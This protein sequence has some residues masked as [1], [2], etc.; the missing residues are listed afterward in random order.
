MD[1]QALLSEASS[2]H[3]WII[4]LRRTIHRNPELM[5]EEVETSRLVQSTLGEL[6]IPFEAGIAET[7]V[8]ATLGNGAGPCVA[9]RADMDALPIQ[10]QADVDFRSEVAGKMHACGH[11]CHTAMLLG[12]AKLLK[13]HEDK[14]SG[15]VK[16]VFQPA[17]EGGAGGQRMREHGILKSPDVQRIFGLHVWPMV[18][19]G[20]I[21]SRVGTFLAATAC[22]E[23]NVVGRGGHAAMPHLAVD[24]IATSA[25]IVS[26]LQ[27]IVSRETDPLEP[28]VISVTSIHAGEAFNVIPAEAQMKGTIRTLTPEHMLRVKQRLTEVVQGIAAA[29]QCEA[30]V[31]FPGPG[32]PP[33]VNDA[34]CWQTAQKIWG[35]QFGADTV[36]QSLPIMG[37]E[38][39][40]FYTEEVPGCFVGLGIQNAANG[41]TYSV[42]HP[43]FKVDESALPV[44]SALHAAFA[45]ASLAELGSV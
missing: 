5:Y 41:C 13:K 42:H 12:A 27:T 18:P 25:K 20:T 7:G 39:F 16:L 37:G 40:A 15:T 17:E 44:G 26:E 6:G 11:D 45:F 9:L 22:L 21:A 1:F 29:N 19:T 35:T 28:L 10:E 31:A 43:M 8:L 24:P 34:D 14:I 32:Y 23:I 33:T 2:L 36:I 3:D 4:D 30:T 38:D